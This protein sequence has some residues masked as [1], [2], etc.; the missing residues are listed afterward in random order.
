MGNNPVVSGK[1]DFC[2]DMRPGSHARGFLCAKPGFCFVFF[3]E[4]KTI[5]TSIY[6]RRMFVHVGCNAL[7][8]VAEVQVQY[9]AHKYACW[10]HHWGLRRFATATQRVFDSTSS[11]T[12][13][14]RLHIR[15]GGSGPQS[16]CGRYRG[17]MRQWLGFQGSYSD[18]SA[19]FSDDQYRLHGGTAAFVSVA[20]F[21]VANCLE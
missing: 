15:A 3:S 6:R 20:S 21:T 4:K 14:F 1:R 10:P 18:L 13:R 7:R 17:S 8:G 16:G 11:S 2:M 5:A 9:M 12:S 19:P